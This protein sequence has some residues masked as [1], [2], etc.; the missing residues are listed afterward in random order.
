MKIHKKYLILNP[1]IKH[2]IFG[3]T[4]KP[5]KATSEILEEIADEYGV[6]IGVIVRPTHRYDLN[7][8]DALYHSVVKRRLRQYPFPL[9]QDH[10]R[11]DYALAVCEM[12]TDRVIQRSFWRA[13]RRNANGDIDEDLLP[14]ELL[15]WYVDSSDEEDT[16]P[17]HDSDVEITK[18]EHT[19]WVLVIIFSLCIWIYSILY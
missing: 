10:I 15:D 7:A 2:W 12:S 1:Q 17:E 3:Y 16:V 6:F 13:H 19:W 5:T 11:R 8:C 4:G 14:K 18:S 9:C